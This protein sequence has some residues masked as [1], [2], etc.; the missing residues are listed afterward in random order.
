MRPL[1][2]AWNTFISSSKTKLICILIPSSWYTWH[3]YVFIEIQNLV[4]RLSSFFKC[5][6][7]IKKLL[8]SYKFSRYFKGYIVKCKLNCLLSRQI[9]LY[10]QSLAHIQFDIIKKTWEWFSFRRSLILT[11]HW[12]A[13]PFLRAGVRGMGLLSLIYVWENVLLGDINQIT[14]GLVMG[15]V[16]R[17]RGCWG[18]V[19]SVRGS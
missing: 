14:D 3:G 6:L 10:S 15:E 13:E 12:T 17:G 8:N 19:R 5:W 2:V 11:P 9:S 4:M 1:T 18:G 7:N 16:A